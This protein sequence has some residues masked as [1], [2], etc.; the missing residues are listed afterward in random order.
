[1]LIHC[2]LP[3]MIGPTLEFWKLLQVFQTIAKEVV[4]RL[5]DSQEQQAAGLQGP[6]PG[7][8]VG[9]N[10]PTRKPKKSGCC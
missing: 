10:A 5:R 8:R 6:P 2:N 1:M 3:A 7:V 4:A 9:L